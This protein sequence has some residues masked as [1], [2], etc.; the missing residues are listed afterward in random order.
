MTRFTTLA[1]VILGLIVCAGCNRRSNDA[2]AR[3]AD[4]IKDLNDSDPRVRL[5]AVHS[6]S[7]YNYGERAAKAVSALTGLL[8][9]S[10]PNI[11][12]A[13]ADTLGCIGFS[14]RAATP[15]LME[16][17]LD[18]NPSVRASVLMALSE[19][20]GLTSDEV[21]AIGEYLQDP[22]RVVRIEAAEALAGAGTSAEPALGA[23]EAALS[24]SDHAVRAC[25]AKA[26]GAIGPSAGSAVTKV[27]ALLEDHERVVRSSAARALGK[28][29]KAAEAATPALTVLLGDTHANV[30]VAAA[31]SL[32]RIDGRI[33]ETVP[34]LIDCLGAKESHLMSGSTVPRVLPNRHV[35]RAAVRT[36]GEM[37]PAA[38]PAVDALMKARAEGDSAIKKVIDSAIKRI[39]KHEKE[40]G[41]K[42]SGTNGTAVSKCLPKYTLHIQPSLGRTTG[43]PRREPGDHVMV[44]ALTGAYVAP[45]CREA[46]RAG[47]IDKFLK[48]LYI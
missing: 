29:G 2:D 36:L 17:L 15:A 21:V 26:I 3:M 39:T 24:D 38:L 46:S 47:R 40:E 30:R 4:R 37:G 5:R 48:K 31:E 6:L 43:L 45:T 42:G 34:V 1:Y 27:V 23:L 20:G 22:R 19:I 25:A 33:K 7:A 8:V 41:K 16:A 12:T 11:R 35:R 10:D 18:K 32:W 9:D 13:A 44:T 14:A 28:I